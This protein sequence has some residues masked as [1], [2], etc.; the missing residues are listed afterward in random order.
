MTD[1][2]HIIAFAPA[3]I[4]NVGPC[5]DIMGYALDYVGDFVEVF[6]IENNPDRLIFE[7]PQGPYADSLSFS[8][9]PKEKNCAYFVASQI[10][11]TYK[12]VHKNVNFSLKLKLHKYMPLESGMGSSGASSA[13]A[14]KAMFKILDYKYPPEELFNTLCMGEEMTAGTPHADNVFPS[15]YGG[16]HFIATRA[17]ERSIIE[18]NFENLFSVVVKPK[19][20]SVATSDSRKA[21]RDFLINYYLTPDQDEACSKLLLLIID[22][23]ILAARMMRAVLNK[24]VKQLGSVLHNN[25]FLENARRQFMPFLDQIKLAAISAGA[26]GCSIAG[27]GPSIVAITD[28]IDATENIR[29][30]MLDTLGGSNRCN[31]LISP[32]ARYHKGARIID[33]IEKFY[34]DGKKHHS[35]FDQ[36]DNYFFMEGRIMKM[37]YIKSKVNA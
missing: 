13:A 3:S 24:D 19:N 27:S 33:S 26:F 15:F 25:P 21:I 22:Q 4:A 6:K 20:I 10:W 28:K 35:F 7:E 5:F 16:F 12:A 23:Q 9:V 17:R 32:C 1:Q 11:S 29:D 18:E 8:K 31:W 37:G 36:I 14:A 34:Q 2:T 30:A